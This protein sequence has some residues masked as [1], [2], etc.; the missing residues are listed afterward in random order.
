LLGV[1]RIVP[2]I[3]VFQFAAYF[4]QTFVFN[5]VVKDTS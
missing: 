3:G 4:D 2:D 5:V 1:I